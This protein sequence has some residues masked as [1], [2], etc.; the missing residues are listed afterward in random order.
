[1]TIYQEIQD[2]VS[3][4]FP[5]LFGSDLPAAPLTINET[6]KEFTGD[7]T[8]VVFPLLKATKKNPEESARIIGEYLVNNMASVTDFNVIKGFLNLTI[9]DAYWLNYLQAPEQHHTISPKQEKVLIEYSSPNTNKPLHL[10]HIRNNVLGYALAG[11]YQANGYPV[12]KANLINDRGIHICKSMLAW[13]KFGNGE[14]P[15]S[16]GLKGDKLVGKYY[17]AFDKAYKQEIDAL[18]QE[19]MPKEEAEKKA[20]ILLEAQEMLRAWEQGDD[21]VIS[22]WKTMN[23]WV[24]DGF[25]I[26]Y[27][28]LGVD[29]DQYYYESNTYLLGKD[30]V[31]DG[32]ARGVFFKK[33][34]GSVWI[35]LTADGLDQKLVLRADGTS[36]YITQDIGTADLKYRDFQMQQSIYVVG[37]EQDY[38]FKVLKLILQKLGKPYAD[39]IQH[40]SYGM[41]DLPS[42]KM[43]SREGTVVDADDLMEDMIANAREQTEALGKIEDFTEAEKQALFHTIGLGALKFFLLRV[44]PKKRILFDPKE[45]IDLHGYTGPFVQYT[46]ARTRSILRKAQEQQLTTAAEATTHPL[47]TTEK[48]LTK[49]LYKYPFIL[50]DSCKEMNPAKMVDYAYELAKT[51]N[52]F[53]H[54]CP[55]L[56]A[57]NKAEQ[58]RRLQLTRHTGD[59]IRQCF[60]I[61]GIEVPERM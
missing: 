51:Y 41:V 34:D 4:G 52:K 8:L 57:E 36:V 15:A 21:A 56:A 23:Q 18:V 13:Q 29:F 37:N 5:A 2:A 61:V 47:H 50:E 53:Y 11:I 17:V 3:T 31:E 20:P 39:G 10:G 7:L 16:S 59:T 33:E 60:A 6:P 46:Y 43:K 25:A 24:Y 32:L 58:Q 35:D 40:F 55:I 1:M 42:G 14:T 19:G 30:I 9:S 26:T 48:E 27:K 54:D 45:S 22:L 44:D 49:A 12:V 28:N 38:H